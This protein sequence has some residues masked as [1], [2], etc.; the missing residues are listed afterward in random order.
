MAN[1]ISTELKNLIGFLKN[2][3][4]EIVVICFAT[5]FMILHSYREI[6]N[7]WISSFIYFGIF[8][9]LT[10]LIFLRKNPLDF[11]LRLGNYRLWLPY[12]LIF[13][14]IA[15]PILYFTSDMSSVQGYYRSGRNFDL[16][17][18]A[19]QM[20]VYMLGWE[21]LFRGFML[22]GL[23]EKFKEG[24]IIIQ[25]IPFVLLHFG[26][27]EIETISTIFTGLLWGYICYRGKSFWP[28][29]IMH[30]V[31]NISNKAFV[32]GLV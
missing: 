23:K 6:E 1:I 26:K 11:G 3:Y 16:L 20:G 29:Y 27:P 8:P 14:A 22:F 10:I 18:Y 15:I 32:L 7:F 24:S 21:F 28:A 5:L 19:L 30:M 9:V 25:M 4:N 13:L 31:V 12:V 17:K 2:W